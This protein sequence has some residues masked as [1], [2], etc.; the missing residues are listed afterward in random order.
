ML[1]IPS[2]AALADGIIAT[3]SRPIYAPGQEVLV[4]GT[5]PV[6]TKQIPVLIAVVAD[7]GTICATS[8]VLPSSDGNFISAPMDMHGCG[9]GHYEARVSYDQA[10][11][12]ASFEVL[13]KTKLDAESTLKIRIIESIVSEG[14]DLANAKVRQFIQDG[15]S[16]PSEIAEEYSQGISESSA[17][18]SAAEFGDADAAKSHAEI[19]TSSLR[20]V[21]V[22][23]NSVESK[24]ELSNFVADSNDTSS[25][26]SVKQ[27]LSQLAQYADRLHRLAAQNGYGNDTWS[28]N[29]KGMLD[30]ADSLLGSGDIQHA[31]MKLT[32]AEA[33]LEQVRIQLVDQARMS[34]ASSALSSQSSNGTAKSKLA[35]LAG[36]IERSA[37]YLL[38]QSIPQPARDLL[39][40]SISLVG[41]A[42]DD[43][44]KGDLKD[45]KKLLASAFGDLDSAK[46]I[47]EAPQNNGQ[48]DS[49][50]HG[51][52][53]DSNSNNGRGSSGNDNNSNGHE[54]GNSTSSKG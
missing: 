1:L 2:C 16:L 47:I 32:E 28:D 45:A 19:A 21:I 20:D 33:L 30:Q 12:T 22:L 10:S 24:S 34:A 29:I 40:E 49:S 5:V 11:A 52:G 35:N 44:S 8:A 6:D 3:T 41:Q 37:N 31:K 36:H 14:R 53:S 15:K 13:R 23:L 48:A 27:T 51:D 4:L 17:A 54:N 18:L 46:K 9:K 43:L 50:G 39:N 38:S 7:N 26:Y 25:Y 42:R